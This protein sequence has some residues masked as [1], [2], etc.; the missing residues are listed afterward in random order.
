MEIPIGFLA[1]LAVSIIT[2]HADEDVYDC[3]WTEWGPCEGKDGKDCGPGVM[4]RYH[5][6]EALHGGEDCIGPNEKEC[7]LKECK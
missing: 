3:E 5:E 6:Q 1:I 4:V 7:N 2:I